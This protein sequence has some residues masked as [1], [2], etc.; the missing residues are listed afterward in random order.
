MAPKVT[1][2][3]NVIAISRPIALAHCRLQLT[4]R[5]KTSFTDYWQ[6]KLS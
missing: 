4:A 2:E 1:V 6:D 5:H 3:E